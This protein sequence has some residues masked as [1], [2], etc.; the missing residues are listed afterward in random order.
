MSVTWTIDRAISPQRFLYSFARGG[1]GERHV[2]PS[3]ILVVW[4]LGTLPT[5][6]QVILFGKLKGAT[7][8]T[9]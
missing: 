4:R 5:S 3:Q 1:M 6:P 2:P 7:F 9:R 8:I